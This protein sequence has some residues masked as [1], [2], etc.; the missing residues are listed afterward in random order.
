M[1]TAPGSTVGRTGA[2]RAK[3]AV[4]ACHLA[5]LC[6]ARVLVYLARRPPGTTATHAQLVRTAGKAAAALDP[7]LDALLR[8]ELLER[9]AGSNPAYRLRAAASAISMEDVASVWT[10]LTP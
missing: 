1:V 10:N 7:S 2:K 5:D 9:T 4:V 6:V 8:A 3:A